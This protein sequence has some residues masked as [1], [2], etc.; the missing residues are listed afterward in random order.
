LSAV[1]AVPQGVANAVAWGVGFGLFLGLCRALATMRQQSIGIWTAFAM[2]VCALSIL[3]VPSAVF[4]G[5]AW[6]GVLIGISVWAYVHR[7]PAIAV[8]L[9][10]LA[11]F[12]RELSA[13]YCVACTLIAAV[14]RRWRELEVW[15]AGASLYAVYFG[16]HVTQ[17]WAQ[18]L[19]TDLAHSSGWLEFG[20]LPFLVSTVHWQPLLL[21]LPLPLTAL[22]L[23]LIVAGVANARAPL[24]LRAASGLYIVFFLV[25][26]KSFNSY[27]GLMA[28]P[29]WALASGYGVETVGQAFKTAF[30]PLGSSRI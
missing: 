8:P 30:A 1:S 19:P 28:G 26:G 6:A 9:A 2:Q 21:A 24:H 22:A 29:T 15:I 11:L 7:R 16:W 12:V 20:G 18:R 5:E 3:A 10:L 17:V 25:V 13:P 27:W 23:V 14:N 4:L